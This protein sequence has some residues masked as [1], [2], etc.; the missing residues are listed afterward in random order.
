MTRKRKKAKRKKSGRRPVRVGDIRA[1]VDDDLLLLADEETP[2][3]SRWNR[4]RKRRISL[5]VDVE[6][7]DWFKSKGPGYQTRMNR[8]LRRVMLEGKKREG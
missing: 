2:A 1:S 6:V 3:E 8:I 7:V 5:R 4:P